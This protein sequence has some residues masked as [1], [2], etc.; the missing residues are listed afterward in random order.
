[1]KFKNIFFG[2]FKTLLLTI[3][4]YSGTLY[5]SY[6]YLDLQ[7]YQSRSVSPYF[8]ERVQGTNDLLKVIDM[9]N[10]FQ[11]KTYDLTLQTDIDLYNAEVKPVLLKWK[12][13]VASPETESSFASHLSARM[14]WNIERN[15]NKSLLPREVHV[16]IYEGNIESISYMENPAMQ[17]P[18]IDIIVANPE[19]LIVAQTTTVK[20]GGS[21]LLDYIAQSYKE[22]NIERI[23]LYASKDEYYAQRGWKIEPYSGSSCGDPLS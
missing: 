11:F 22:K 9:Q 15:L 6:M 4:F 17:V 3:I 1:M 18:K 10:N 23:R 13:N 8:F 20:G 21:A 16:A 12:I 19:G 14:E 7:N 2:F 5:A